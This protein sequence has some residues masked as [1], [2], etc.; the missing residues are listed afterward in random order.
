[1]TGRTAQWCLLV[2][3][4]PAVVL[5]ARRL[6]DMGRTAWLQ[7]AS[8]GTQLEAVVPIAALVASAGLALWGCLGGG[9]AGASR[10]AVPAS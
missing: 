7:F 3:L 6:H 2:L 5:H 1:M 10:P 4:F 8:P 9:Q